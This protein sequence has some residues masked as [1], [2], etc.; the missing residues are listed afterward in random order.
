MARRLCTWLGLMA[1]GVVFT[2]CME[3]DPYIHCPFSN[4]IEQTCVQAQ[5]S[6]GY[7]CVVGSH[8]FCSEQLCVSWVESEPFCS[9]GCEKDA[10]CEGNAHCLQHLD[11][12]A[13]SSVPPR[14]CVPD[15]F[16]CGDGT[17]QSHEATGACPVD[18]DSSSGLSGGDN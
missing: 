8:P 14:V 9:R 1:L 5:D 6:V 18:C 12:P 10:D 11:N 15:G 3:D 2:G 13:N 17:C 7:T 4:S 16:L